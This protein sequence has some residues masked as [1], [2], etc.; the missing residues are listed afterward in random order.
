MNQ[1]NIAQ[2]RQLIEGALSLLDEESLKF[3][4]G[5]GMTMRQEFRAAIE[6][7]LGE[8]CSPGAVGFLF[9]RM[10]NQTIPELSAL[11][12]EVSEFDF[13]DYLTSK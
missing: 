9:A 7:T 5:S 3:K 6:N 10:A 11:G 8:D 2:R 4:P 12:F 1:L 13:R